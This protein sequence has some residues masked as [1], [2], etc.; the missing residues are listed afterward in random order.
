[1]KK[2][3][4]STLTQISKHLNLSIST[5]SRAINGQSK[6]YRI[7]EKTTKL[8]IEA[9]KKFKYEPN[10]LARS[11]RL[12]KSNTI[13][14]IVPD[15]TNPFFAVIVRWIENAAR[16]NDKTIFISDSNNDTEFE[17]IAIK[18][19]SSRK[20]D[21]LIVAPVGDES[22]HLSETNQLDIPIVIIDRHLDKLN[23]PFVGSN[24][25][26]GSKEAT[27]YLIGKGHQ[28]IAFNQG[29]QKS[30][31]NLD[32]VRGYCDALKENRIT[33]NHNLIVGENFNEQS[34]YEAAKF[35]LSKNTCITAIFTASNQIALGTIK[36][37]K[38][39]K[40]HIPND[41]SLLSFDNQSYWDYFSPPI[42]TVEQQTKKIADKAYNLLSEMINHNK[43]VGTSKIQLSTKII[44]RKSVKEKVRKAWT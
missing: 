18:A 24:N 39:K 12:K 34:G 2:N 33:I 27:N 8:I 28:K 14:V 43:I 11:L 9:A 25:Y 17:K 22:F 21:G 10:E 32:R 5:V 42:T 38:E 37:I 16:L 44:I 30:K 6:K 29:L 31:L 41:I 23:L 15:I 36:A 19:F 4:D 1:M 13:G 40:L 3:T 7:S 35:L 20:I 26:E